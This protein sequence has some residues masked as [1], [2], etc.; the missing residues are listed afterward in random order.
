MDIEQMTC[1]ECGK[2][3]IKANWNLSTVLTINKTG[4]PIS[5]KG[6]IEYCDKCG[7]LETTGLEPFNARV[8]MVEGKIIYE[9]N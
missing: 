8:Q 7:Y 4:I 2:Q 5:R 1:P 6:T 3:A 9:T